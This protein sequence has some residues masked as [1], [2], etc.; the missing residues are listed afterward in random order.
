MLLRTVA[1]LAVAAVLTVVFLRRQEDDMPDGTDD[2]R[3]GDGP[4]GR[5]P[6]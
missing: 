4:D 1:T 2:D 5:G 3:P 6:E